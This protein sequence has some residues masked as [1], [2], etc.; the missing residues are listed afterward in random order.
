MRQALNGMLLLSLLLCAA[1]ATSQS[2]RPEPG[3]PSLPPVPEDPLALV[4]EDPQ[5]VAVVNVQALTSSPLFER[6]RPYL[7]RATCIQLADW[8]PLLSATNHA[9][10]A[11]RHKP[12][13]EPEWL[14]VLSG[15]YTEAD[16]HRVL[17]LA[18][19]QSRSASAEPAREMPDGSG[20]FRVTEQGTLAVSQLDGRVLV[21]GT[22]AW[23]R[24]ALASVSQPTTNFLGS[25]LWRNIGPQLGCSERTACLLSVANSTNARQLERGLSGAGAKQLGQEL[26]RADSALALTLSDGLALGFAAQVG[27]AEAAQVA[28]R[29]LRDWLWQANLVVRLTGLPAVLDRTKLSTQAALVRAELEVTQAE[30]D[31]YEARAK[32]LFDR[33]APSCSADAQSL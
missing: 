32:P 31:A 28:E 1:C 25:G 22:T 14:L 5:S 17:E 12:D 4:V 21:L 26:E 29:A 19:Q 30:L 9:A 3:S 10:L 24:A 16:A 27:S 11:A 6:L 8:K 18:R 23:L 33:Q 7:E 2:A 20:R 13:Q 15:R